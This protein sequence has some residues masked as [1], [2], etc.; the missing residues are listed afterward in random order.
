MGRAWDRAAIPATDLP[1]RAAAQIAT[2]VVRARPTDESF[3]YRF[4]LIWPANDCATILPS[5]TTCVS[6]AIA[7]TLSAVSADHS[8][9]AKSPSIDSSCIENVVPGCPNSWIRARKNSRIGS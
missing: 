6:V 4:D 7:Y 9:Y 1:D 3:D 8:E 5:R 2:S